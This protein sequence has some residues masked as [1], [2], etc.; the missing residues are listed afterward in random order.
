MLFKN[1]N[2]NKITHL[3]NCSDELTRDHLYVIAA[4]MKYGPKELE[5]ASQLLLT[6]SA[7]LL[8]LILQIPEA[9]GMIPDVV[10]DR[11]YNKNE[12]IVENELSGEDIALVAYRN[13]DEDSLKVYKNLRK[14]HALAI[15]N[16]EKDCKRVVLNLGG[17]DYRY[18]PVYFDR[19]NY[20]ENDP[21]LEKTRI[22]S[23]DQFIHELDLLRPDVKELVDK[24]ESQK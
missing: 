13:A 10:I 12:Q 23:R 6:D 19:Y 18:T 21:Q 14:S 1:E 7:F 20:G 9:S 4:V 8:R 2:K 17:E 22:A 15:R 3:K 5:H 16:F 11:F 24:T